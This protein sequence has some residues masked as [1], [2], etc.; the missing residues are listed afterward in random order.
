L[1]EFCVGEAELRVL[2]LIAVVALALVC[3]LV[4]ARAEKRVALVI[5]N[6]A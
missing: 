3:A 6:G 1:T 5:G 2:Q 4:P